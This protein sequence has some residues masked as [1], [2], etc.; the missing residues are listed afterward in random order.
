M[1]WKRDWEEKLLT[2]YKECSWDSIEELLKD[3]YEIA[4]KDINFEHQYT[5]LVL[6][7]LQL[8]AEYG[9]EKISF[10]QWKSFRAYV[11]EVK[12]KEIKIED[13]FGESKQ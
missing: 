9:I 5:H 1:N 11:H 2:E 6:F 12:R 8:L 7:N 10:P 13:L 3:A 4:K